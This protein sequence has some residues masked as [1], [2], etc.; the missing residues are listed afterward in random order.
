MLAATIVNGKMMIYVEDLQIPHILHL[1]P[2]VVEQEK[3]SIRN[4]KH[5]IAV[6]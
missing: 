5:W 3:D 6:N 2:V 1:C 4:A